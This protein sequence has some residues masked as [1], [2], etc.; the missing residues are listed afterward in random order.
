MEQM[1]RSK[2][3]K[4][5]PEC[6][7][8]ATGQATVLR[9]DPETGGTILIPVELIEDRFYMVTASARAFPGHN[10]IDELDH[11]DLID[12]IKEWD[13]GDGIVLDGMKEGDE[14]I[15]QWESPGY[16]E[17]KVYRAR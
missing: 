13:L 9:N 5:A 16:D 12:K 6:K 2:F 11:L 8:M 3:D 14:I 10:V 17:V 4:I 15:L 7:S 1:K